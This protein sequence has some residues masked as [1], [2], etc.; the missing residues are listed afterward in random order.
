MTW[1]VYRRM[2]LVNFVGQACLSFD[3]EP[4]GLLGKLLDEHE[5]VEMEY[6]GACL[7]LHTG[8]R[9]GWI[10]P[11]GRQGSGS[12][13]PISMEAWAD[14]EPLWLSAKTRIGKAAD[15]LARSE[16]EWLRLCWQDPAM[17]FV[18]YDSQ[19]KKAVWH[20]LRFS[21][22]QL[23]LLFPPKDDAGGADEAHPSMGAN[24]SGAKPMAPISTAGAEKL[25]RR[26]FDQKRK[27]KEE[28]SKDN[29]AAA[30]QEAARTE[31]K[32]LTRNRARSLV[33]QFGED[34]IRRRGRSS[35]N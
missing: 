24:T 17:R 32:L 16:I 9:E 14:L 19:S 3:R 5:P 35:K 1:M 12:W 6:Y 26:Y 8:C 23:V 2:L 34:C 13:H 33:D 28:G 25:A 18:L 15:P 29:H 27:A 31:G 4:P 10:T 22:A 30:L 20:S 7:A 11:E 21:A